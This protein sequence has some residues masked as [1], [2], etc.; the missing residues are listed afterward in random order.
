MIVYPPI[1]ITDSKLVSSNIPEPDADRGEVEWVSG[2]E[3]A[4]GAEVI[5]ASLH[6]KYKALVAIASGDTTTPESDPLKW[7]Y[8]GATNRWAMFE[9]GRAN[10]TVGQPGEPLIV[11]VNPMTRID[12]VAVVG[13]DASVVTVRVYVG[14]VVVEER[15]SSLTTRMVLNWFDYFFNDFTYQTDNIFSNLPMYANAQIEVELTNGDLAP[16][17]KSLIVCRRVDLGRTVLDPS[18]SGA[19]YSRIIRDTEFGDVSRIIERR[20][21]PTTKQKVHIDDSNRAD[22]IRETLISIRSKPALFSGLDEENS[23]P[24]FSSF[25]IYGLLKDWTLNASG[26]QWGTLSIDLEEL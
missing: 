17:I 26:I 5:R 18:L 3:Y 15:T 13:M 4:A 8:V 24:W 16:S 25:L 19:N 23:N 2:S 1:E 20:F 21:V 22:L 6:R 10:A 9:S 14:G 11:R 7:Q 12:S